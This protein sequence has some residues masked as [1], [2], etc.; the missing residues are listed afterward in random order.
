MS[1]VPGPGTVTPTRRLIQIQSVSM[2]VMAINWV[3][4]LV[5]RNVSALLELTLGML[6]LAGAFWMARRGRFVGATN[7]TLATLTL[8]TVAM[9]WTFQGLHDGAL[10]AFP[11]ILVFAA[12]LGS[13][14]LFVT[15]ATF[16]L[17][18]MGLVLA[19]SLQGWHT[20]VVQGVTVGMFVGLV[21]V[22]VGSAFGIW[23]L[24]RDLR[25]TLVQLKEENLRVVQSQAHI[26]FLAN[27]DGLTGLPNRILGRD[28]LHLAV[29]QAQRNDS[30]AAILH[31]DLDNFK[32]INDSL[33][34][35]TG[36]QLLLDA[37]D[38]IQGALH[39][40]DT[41]CRQGGDEFLV[42]LGNL[43]SGDE[44]AAGAT[45]IMAALAEPFRVQGMDVPMTASLGLALYPED[46]LDFDTLLQKADTAMYQAKAAG[47][48]HFRFFDPAM[49]TTMVE[50]LHLA[51]GL[52]TAVQRGELVLHYQ[53]QIHLR[54]GRIVGAEA[55]LRWQHP[56]RG[57]LLPDTFIPVAERSGQIGEIGKWVMEEA[58]RQ[59]RNWRD[60]GLDLVMSVNLSPVQFKRDDLESTV[61]GALAEAGIP[62]SCIELE[63]TE[64]MLI[65]DSP[66]LTQK[67]RNLRG[68]GLSFSIDDFGTG[69]SNLSYLQRFDVERLK[70]DQSFVKRLTQGPQDEALVLAI[71][72]MAKSLHL[73][74]VAEGI[75]DEATLERLEAMACDIGQGFHWSHAIPSEEFLS[76]YQRWPKG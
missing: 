40:T 21:A 36:D 57:L 52:H 4:C 29:S 33:G 14:R 73:G 64:S 46:G 24:A 74:I 44:A 10:L 8:L 50:Y 39:A 19:A 31:L 55:L 32:T 43:P 65:D 60:Q 61:R 2:A 16:M 34:H 25:R 51:S 66:A 27:F 69:Y 67:L 12:I 7:L 72:Q 56:E 53:P 49:N 23:V 45:R 63:L 37:R 76:F 20:F 71:I 41:L 18:A 3:I 47:R 17:V 38:R 42:I 59:A 6:L 58:C 5:Q 15:L 11:G 26:D 62:A 1:A 30:F 68:M 13:G 54:Y 75:E 70:I 28:Y 48:N 9:M 22:L 35:R